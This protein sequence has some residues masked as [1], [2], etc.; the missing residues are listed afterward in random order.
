MEM[1][2]IHLK[3]M[4]IKKVGDRVRIGSQ[5]KQLR[6]KEFKKASK[7]LSNRV[8]SRRSSV[9]SNSWLTLL[10][11]RLPRWILQHTHHH[12]PVPLDLYRLLVPLLLVRGL[13][14]VCLDTSP[15][16]IHR[17]SSMMPDL[18]LDL[19]HPSWIKKIVLSARN[20]IQG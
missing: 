16:T 11:N 2:Q 12:R 3:D 18:Q 5:A 10:S 20:N 9:C 4:G 19:A 17:R 1:D 6:N 8:R 7:R 14:N 15:A 13:R